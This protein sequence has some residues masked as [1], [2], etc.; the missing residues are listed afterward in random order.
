MNKKINKNIIVFELGTSFLII[1]MLYIWF[2]FYA[3]INS[4]DMYMQSQ[5]IEIEDKINAANYCEVS[6]DCV[7]IYDP[8]LTF[9]CEGFK[10][11][12][13]KE[14]EII[15]EE[16]KQFE[17]SRPFSKNY[18]NTIKN[19]SM[20]V[21]SVCENNKCVKGCP[22]TSDYGKLCT[23]DSQCEGFCVIENKQEITDAYNKYFLSQVLNKKITV[24]L[25]DFEEKGV[26]VKLVCSKN[27]GN[28]S[29][30]PKFENGEYKTGW[31]K[32]GC[33]K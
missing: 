20:V 7:E 1:S 33:I 8:N 25:D 24:K 5:H 32:S 14:I 22:L 4:D 15:N 19:S 23:D 9:S 12:N 16:I 26:K 27:L 11:V 29:C 6:S 30:Y 3:P 21:F 17:L 2:Y 18:C 13:K 10:F 28:D 31:N